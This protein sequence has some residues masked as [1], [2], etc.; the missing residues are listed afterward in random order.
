MRRELSSG[1]GWAGWR[2]GRAGEGGCCGA[3]GRARETCTGASSASAASGRRRNA[4]V[5]VRWRDR[6]L[7]DIC[8]L[9][10]WERTWRFVG[11]CA[12][13][14]GV[15]ASHP[16]CAVLVILPSQ[17]VAR[18]WSGWR[19]APPPV[20]VVVMALFAPRLTK[21]S[22]AHATTQ[23]SYPPRAAWRPRR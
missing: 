13:V 3:G 1:D 9:W 17:V 19:A 20:I 12:V 21:T 7:W 18:R 4:G 11:I 10:V 6:L 23:L 2:P 15:I 22:C 5:E 14:A 8:T 16:H